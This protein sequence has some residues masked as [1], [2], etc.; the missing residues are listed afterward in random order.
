LKDDTHFNPYGA[1][2]LAKCVVIGLRAEVP[3]LAQYIA[4]H[5]KPFD[6]MHPDQAT[7]WQWPASPARVSARPDGS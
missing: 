4:P 3:A 2:Q 1:Y 7:D 6:P 5:F